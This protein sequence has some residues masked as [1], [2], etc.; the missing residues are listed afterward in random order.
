MYDERLADRSVQQLNP[1]LR[2]VSREVSHSGS[3]RAQWTKGAEAQRDTPRRG[4]MITM[5]V[6]LRDYALSTNAPTKR[7]ACDELLA[8]RLDAE[9]RMPMS[10]T[11]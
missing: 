5:S 1:Q 2:V 4:M 8:A 3:T 6:A 10:G 9:C 7:S 11:L